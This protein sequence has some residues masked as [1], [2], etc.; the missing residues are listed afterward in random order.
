MPPRKRP[1]KP[2]LKKK[3]VKRAKV[4]RKKKVQPVLD[5]AHAPA[6]TLGNIPWAYGDTRI[7]AMVRDPWVV[8]A[9]W[10]F[11]DQDLAR[12]RKEVGSPDAGCALR[13]YETSLRQFD[14][15]NANWY[16][17]IPIDRQTNMYYV[18]TNRPGATFHSD[19]GVK[20]HEGWFAKIARSG[21]VETPRD[22]ASPDT[23]VEWMTVPQIAP[24]PEYRHRFTPRPWTEPP[25]PRAEIERTLTALTGEG[26]SR[27]EWSEADMGGRVIRWVRWSGPVRR[28]HIRLS[29]EGTF[30]RIEIIF[31]AERRIMEDRVVYGP[32]NVTI[33]TIDESGVRRV[34]ERLQ[35]H[36]S[37]TEES[38]V[39]AHTDAIVFRLLRTYRVEP[40]AQMMGSSEWQWAGSSEARP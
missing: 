15:T 31:Q 9:Y 14:G 7:V 13:V 18:H 34:Y 36:D 2:A 19:I 11:N 27:T 17:D 1:K 20:S 32:W 3:P 21:I 33:E 38:H 39:Q 26:W 29:R 30:T 40:Q 6:P 4:V 8:F 12:A 5:L 25:V 24:P 35:V 16:V 10:E 23:R 37:V 22:A 28:E